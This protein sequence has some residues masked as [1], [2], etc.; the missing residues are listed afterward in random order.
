[1]IFIILVGLYNLFPCPDTFFQYPFIQKLHPLR[2][3]MLFIWRKVV[4]ISKDKSPRISN[5]AV[6]FNK[7]L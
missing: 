6:S 5:L 7:P 1:M 3:Y 2:G 4:N